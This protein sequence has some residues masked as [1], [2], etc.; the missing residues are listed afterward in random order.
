[1]NAEDKR[2][3]IPTGSRSFLFLFICYLSSRSSLQSSFHSLG[4]NGKTPEDNKQKNER[5]YEPVEETKDIQPF[6]PPPSPASQS[7]E[8]VGSW[9]ENLM[10]GKV[11]QGLMPWVSNVWSSIVVSYLQLLLS[12]SFLRFTLL[13][14]SLPFP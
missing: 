2:R 13:T 9:L 7:D 14:H 4:M 11:G 12:L 3:Q 8:L 5:K 1:M 10:V 6:I